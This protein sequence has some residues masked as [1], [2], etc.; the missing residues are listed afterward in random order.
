MRESQA[1]MIRLPRCLLRA[2][3]IAGF[4]VS[5]S[6][7][8]AVARAASDEPGSDAFE[9]RCMQ[10]IE[11]HR[12]GQ[13][14]L[15]RRLLMDLLDPRSEPALTLETGQRLAAARWL[16]GMHWQSGDV[17]AASA[18]LSRELEAAADAGASADARASADAETD[19]EQRASDQEERV[20][21]LELCRMQRELTDDSSCRRAL[22]G[23]ARQKA[24]SGACMAIALEVLYADRGLGSGAGT[25]DRV[26]APRWWARELST[27]GFWTVEGCEAIP[28]AAQWW[29]LH[30]LLTV[31]STATALERLDAAVQAVP[32]DAPLQLLRARALLGLGRLDAAR[33]SVADVLSQPSNGGYPDALLWSAWLRF[34]HMPSLGVTDLT[35]MGRRYP[36]LLRS[37]IIA[38][39]AEPALGAAANTKDVLAKA[40]TDIL[41]WYGDFALVTRQHQRVLA[42]VQGLE[43]AAAVTGQT[44]FFLGDEAGALPKL[45]AAA[46]SSARARH[47][48]HVLNWMKKERYGWW[49]SGEFWVR[50][51]SEDQVLLE[52]EVLPRAQ[53]IL[54]DLERA[55]K[56][57]VP[58]PVRLEF[59]GDA[60]LLHARLG[61]SMVADLQE[62]GQRDASGDGKELVGMYQGAYLGESLVLA[63]PIIAL[64]WGGQP[65][66]RVGAC[67]ELVTLADAATLVW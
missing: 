37:E 15:G 11:A 62:Q 61:G 7:C 30:G 1:L 24:H 19:E 8:P 21:L 35:A 16:A 54:E 65:E 12:R 40:A 47:W 48:L 26:A 18:V 52:Q 9:K 66:A 2:S 34:L 36:T 29:L 13:S 33:R 23:R 55:W 63:S 41:D 32:S 60:R 38:S 57:R 39:V 42:L 49:R 27:P 28:T 46:A 17:D 58:R 44:A 51:V 22:E 6:W 45:E 10:A 3:W 4:A 50:S 25:S 59:F 14:D 53:R 43:N 31:G 20:A 67:C 5:L 64:G 56:V